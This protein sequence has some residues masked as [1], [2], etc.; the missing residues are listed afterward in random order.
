MEP[1]YAVKISL[2]EHTHD[3]IKNPYYWS[4][5]KHDK[6]WHQIAFGWESSP[7]KCFSAALDHYNGL[8]LDI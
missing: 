3:N 4:L 1:E 8:L 2:V 7:Q 6:S 5:L